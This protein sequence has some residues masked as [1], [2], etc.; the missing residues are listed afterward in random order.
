MVDEC[1]I[2]SSTKYVADR[3]KDIN[4]EEG[5]EII[6]FDVKSLY[7]NVPVKEA[8]THCTELLYSGQYQKPPVSK[9]TF[10]QLLEICSIDVLMSTPSGYY[11]QIDGLAMGSPPAPLVANG[12]LSKY[13]NQIKGNAKLYTRYMDDILRISIKPK[14]ML[15]SKKLITIIRL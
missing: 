15:N 12:W 3:L 4:L 6:S 5:E 11:R 9:D 2:N 1:N 7:T 10:K 8:I 14:L 13:D